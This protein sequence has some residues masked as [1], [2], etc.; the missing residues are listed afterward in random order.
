MLRGVVGEGPVQ[1]Q[2]GRASTIQVDSVDDSL[3][4]Q[5]FCHFPQVDPAKQR[6]FVDLPSVKLLDQ[7][8]VALC[9]GRGS[10][11]IPGTLRRAV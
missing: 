1:D 9:G 10:A 2:R 8:C 11:P 6:L 4:L 7:E 5:E 3:L